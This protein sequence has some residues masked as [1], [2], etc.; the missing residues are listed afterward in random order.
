M[1]TTVAALGALLYVGVLASPAWAVPVDIDATGDGATREEAVAHALA[2]AVAQVSGVAVSAVQSMSTSLTARAS[3][4]GG[5]VNLSQDEQSALQSVSGGFVKSYRIEGVEP[6]GPGQVTAHVQ[7]TV[8]MFKAKA[9][10]AE[11]RRRIAVAAF[12]DGA[13]GRGAGAALRDK[14]VA[15]LVQARRFAVVD[16][17]KDDEYNSEMALLQGGDA[18]L[19]ERVRVGQVLG[20]D[21]V[22]VG[23]IRVTAP[24]RSERQIPLTG[25]EV[26]STTPGS[27]DVDFQIIEIATR[28]VSWAGSA[29]G[30]GLAQLAGEVVDDIVGAIYPMRLIRFDDPSALI[31]NQGGGTLRPAQR[32]RAFLLGE[33]LVDPYTHESLGQ[34][35]RQVGVVEVTRVDTK[36]SY[37]RLVSGKLPPSDGIPP[38]QIV[39]RPA[40]AEAAPPQGARPSRR[41]PPAQGTDV[42]KLPFDK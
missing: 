3:E 8:E 42:V 25:E 6:E 13:G 40:P 9:A 2:S 38:A 34:D 22:V 14:I 10:G 27:T 29:H 39:L 37:A 12:D 4:D 26:V 23:K 15:N 30:S 33:A 24:T 28:Q 1:R 32:F 18:P 16:R 36:V 20:A 31:L 35:E 21:Y 17:S 19:T 41:P 11:A 7:V 5:T